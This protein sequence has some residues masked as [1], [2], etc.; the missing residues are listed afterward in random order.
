MKPLIPRSQYGTDEAFRDDIRVLRRCGWN[1]VTTTANLQTSGDYFAADVLGVPVL[2]RNFDGELIAFRNVCAHRHC[3]LYD[4]GSGRSEDLKCRYHGWHYGADGRTRKIPGAKNFP[5]FDRDTHVL[6]RFQVETCGQLVFVH[7]SRPDGSLIETWGDDHARLEDATDPLRWRVNLD[8]HLDFDADWKIPVEG[9]LESYHLDEVHAGTF[10]HDPG[11][12]NTTHVMSKHGTR[13]ETSLREDSVLQRW[14]ER[15]I[16]LMTGGFEGTYQ[17]LHLF[18]AVM[19]SLNDSLSLVYQVVPIGPGRSRMNVFGF[20][21]AATKNGVVA[22]LWSRAMGRASASMA[23]KV[24]SE[25]AVIFPK[26]QQGIRA[27]EP[28]READT[29]IFGR[30]EERLHAFHVDWVHRQRALLHAET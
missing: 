20:A 29:G 16:R 24:L 27:T 10:G 2:I 12:E 13:F 11:E 18:P 8:S 21:R 9:S 14:E 5:A 28:D 22:K 3:K 6:Q 25:D 7:L 23:M 15:S 26:V 4:D 19:A 1:L 30:C 17:H